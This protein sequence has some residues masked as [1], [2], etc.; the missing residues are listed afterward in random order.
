ML[1]KLFADDTSLF[2]IV[3]DANK[4]FENLGNDLCI[5]NNWAYKWKR[6]FYPDRSKEAQSHPI[7]T[8]N[9]SPAI[10]TTHHK[11]MW[12]ILDE[13]LSSKEHLKKNV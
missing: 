5:I 12:L 13:K 9:N 7:L 8:S 11:H 1:I 2:S 4:Y 10:K 6:S 3:N